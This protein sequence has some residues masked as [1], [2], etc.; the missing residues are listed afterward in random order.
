MFR[1]SRAFQYFLA[2]ILVSGFAL[3]AAQFSFSETINHQPPVFI[4]V[5]NAVVYTASSAQ[6]FCKPQTDSG[7]KRILVFSSNSQ[8]ILA[9]N[10][11]T[12]LRNKVNDP[13]L[14]TSWKWSRNWQRLRNTAEGSCLIFKRPGK[15]AVPEK[16]TTAQDYYEGW[17]S[18]NSKSGTLLRLIC[19][20]T[21][22]DCVILKTSQNTITEHTAEPGKWTVF[23]WN[24]SEPVQLT[25]RSSSSPEIGVLAAEP[26][27][28]FSIWQLPAPGCADNSMREQ[29]A[30]IHPFMIVVLTESENA[31]AISSI[32]RKLFQNTPLLLCIE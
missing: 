20:A 19:K 8:T 28:G 14:F 31:A 17:V 7:T 12:L 11:A 15:L 30:L 24:A 2:V 21:S 16:N 22:D 4:P 29:A 18:C 27:N 32:I 9:E 25:F 13:R 3:A 10:I 1:L 23:E 26:A 5:V 6:F